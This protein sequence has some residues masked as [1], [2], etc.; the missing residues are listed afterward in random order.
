M[1][2]GLN[3]GWSSIAWKD[4]N[5]FSCHSICNLFLFAFRCKW[6]CSLSNCQFLRNHC[7]R[8]HKAH[9][10]RMSAN[11]LVHADF[12]ERCKFAWVN[13]NEALAVV[14]APNAVFIEHA[15]MH[16]WWPLGCTGRRLSWHTAL[17]LSDCY[18]H[19]H[20][21]NLQWNAGTPDQCTPVPNCSPL[22]FA[23]LLTLTD[24]RW[25]DQSTGDCRRAAAELICLF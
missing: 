3:C 12:G 20:H 5:A 21:Y 16:G 1:L 11:W 22:W 18:H 14:C 17:T 24:Q 13:A 25:R 10:I 8:H 7:H 9:L 23:A 2:F 15:S 19:H 6:I 4:L